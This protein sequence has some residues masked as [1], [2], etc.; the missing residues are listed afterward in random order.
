[1]FGPAL[2]TESSKFSAVVVANVH[3]HGSPLVAAPV[4]IKAPGHTGRDRRGEQFEGGL[5]G[6]ALLG[7]LAGST[8]RVAKWIVN[9]HEAGNT[10]GLD[11]VLCATNNHGGD[12]GFFEM[13][14]NQTHGL[15]TDRSKRHQHHGIDAVFFGP[16][17]DLGGISVSAAL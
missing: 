10:C 7:Q 16:L 4:E 1:M 9:K 12:T 14:C 2:I 8:Q 13:P 17:H 3:V 5:D 15:V 11:D 6:V